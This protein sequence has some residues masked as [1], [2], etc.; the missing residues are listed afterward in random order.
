MIRMHHECTYIT[1]RS[2]VAS[3]YCKNQVI[4]ALGYNLFIY[5]FFVFIPVGPVG[6]I[7]TLVDLIR[8]S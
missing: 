2:Y 3:F 7:K 4:D 6:R 1:F 5:F 8:G